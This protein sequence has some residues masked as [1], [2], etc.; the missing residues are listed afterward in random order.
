MSKKFTTF[1]AVLLGTVLFWAIAFTAYEIWLEIEDKSIQSCRTELNSES[2]E[3]EVIC[4]ETEPEE[5]VEKVEA[6]FLESVEE[7]GHLHIGGKAP[8]GVV[9]RPLV[10]HPDAKFYVFFHRMGFGI[11]NNIDCAPLEGR[12][13]QCMEGWLAGDDQPE[14]SD[15]VGLLSEDVKNGMASLVVIS[16]KDSRIIGIYPNHTEADI[17]PI[18][19][20]F[21]EYK[22]SLVECGDKIIKPLLDP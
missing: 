3:K 18:L 7:F 22:E 6:S 9:L 2:G 16:D 11:C 5:A 14:S 15:D 20:Q 4:M 12:V 19:T 10:S 13:I 1:S 17:I 8:Q 21:P